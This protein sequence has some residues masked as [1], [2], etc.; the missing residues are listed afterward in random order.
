MFSLLTER[1]EHPV[2]ATIALLQQLKVNA[3]NTTVNETLQN[4]PDYPSLLSI[5]DALK[6]WHIENVAF[7]V[8]G[9]FKVSY[10]YTVST[11]QILYHPVYK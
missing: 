11:R 4:H 9:T 3:T 1:Y 6:Q 7:K 10:A 8:S 5:S 2:T